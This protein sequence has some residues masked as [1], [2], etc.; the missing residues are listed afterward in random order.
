L[1]HR[2]N[3]LDKGAKFK[4]YFFDQDELDEFSDDEIYEEDDNGV[5]EENEV[6]CKGDDL[7]SGSHHGKSD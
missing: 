5:D 3:Y 1:S 4:F 7:K 6:N 2:Y